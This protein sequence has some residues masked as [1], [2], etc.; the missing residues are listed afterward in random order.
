MSTMHIR[1]RTAIADAELARAARTDLPG[2]TP[3]PR[4]HT[5]RALARVIASLLRPLEPDRV[6]VMTLA[7]VPARRP[8]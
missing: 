5:P 8:R 4:P 2:S 1:P 6:I 3:L 7:A